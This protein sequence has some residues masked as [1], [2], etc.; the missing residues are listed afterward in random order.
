MMRVH[1]VAASDAER[2]PQRKLRWGDYWLKRSLERALAAQGWEVQPALGHNTHVMMHCWGLPLE[3]VPEWT[4]NVL[5]VHSHPATL[6]RVPWGFYDRVVVASA[7]LAERLRVEGVRVDAVNIGA[8]DFVRLDVPLEHDAVFVANNRGGLRP[9]IAALGDLTTLPF[10]LEVWGEGWEMLPAGIWQG[11]YYPYDDLNALYASSAV[12]LN[13]THEDMRQAGIINPRVL[14]AEAAGALVVE[15]NEADVRATVAELVT[16]RH[17]NWREAMPRDF[18]GVTY[19]RLAHDLTAGIEAQLRFDLGCG[20]HK[21]DGFVGVDRVRLDGVDVV[22]DVRQGLPSND[23][24]VDY[25][26]AD[27]LL[28]HIGPEFIDVMNDLHRVLKPGG[29]LTAIVPGVHAPAAAYA[30]PTHVRYFVPETWDY[31]D[32]EHARWR[33]YGQSYGIRPWRVLRREVRDRFIETVMQ[34]VK[35]C[36]CAS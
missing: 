15:P 2:D 28:E 25:I 26:V 32:G 22:W 29:R 12:V 8:T 16:A 5:Y 6:D 20:N 9:I 17:N 4:Y 33:D 36:S 3:R 11:L 14:D 31:F 19:S 35:E 10:R 13:D 18:A 21:R 34:P 1:V 27:N 23:D 30:D 7:Q 24:T